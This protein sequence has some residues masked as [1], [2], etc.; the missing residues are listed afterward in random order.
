MLDICVYTDCN[1]L[2]SINI[3]THIHT[4]AWVRVKVVPDQ[5]FVV[6]SP[7]KWPKKDH[8]CTSTPPLTHSL[9]PSHSC[10]P[11]TDPPPPPIESSNSSSSNS[12]LPPSSLKSSSSNIGNTSNS[13]DVGTQVSRYFIKRVVKPPRYMWSSCSSCE[14]THSLTLFLIHK[15]YSCPHPQPPSRPRTAPPSDTSAEGYTRVYN[16]N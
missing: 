13:K 10:S 14:W 15:G 7:A 3:C 11:N 4:V 8:K 5:D 9:T 6:K 12:S 16:R 2:F 1:F